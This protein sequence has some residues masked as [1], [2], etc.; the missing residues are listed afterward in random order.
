M[1]SIL[2]RILLLNLIWQLHLFVATAYTPDWDSLDSRPLPSWYDE[3]KLG[4]FMHWGLYAVPSHSEW[5]WWNWI[6]AKNPDVNQFMTDNYKPGFK[7]A[8]FGP[9]F[10]AEFFD[11]DVFAKVV[12]SSG[13]KYFVLTSKHHEGY[14]MYP[15]NFSWNW[16][17]VDV[18]PHRDIVGALQKSMTQAKVR[19][20]LYYSLYE[21]FH[22]LYLEDKGTTFTKK[23]YVKSVMMPQ[24]KEIVS[25]Y[26][27][28]VIWSDGDWEASWQYWNS[29]SFISWLYNESPV[30]KT[31]VVN[32]RWGV[33]TLCQHGDF[34]TCT[35]KYD[36]GRLINRKW[37]RC[38]TLDRYSW[39]FRRTATYQDILTVEEVIA[40]LAK[41]ISCGGNLLLNVGPTHDGR[42]IP[43]FEERLA[44]LGKF[45]SL[46][47]EAIFGT[48]PWI[49]QNDT[50]TPDIWYTSRKRNPTFGSSSPQLYHKQKSIDTIVYAFVLQWPKSGLLELGAPKGTS[51]TA[52]TLLGY[53]GTLNYLVDT[54]T[55]HVVVDFSS[56]FLA[57]MPT[58]LPKTWVLK[59]EYLATDH[60][61]PEILVPQ[62]D[63][64]GREYKRQLKAKSQPNML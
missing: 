38:M 46:N 31:V 10:T 30:S 21:W 37:E 49:Y 35:D 43:I 33:G 34:L 57:D 54:S 15:S 29:T 9:Q 22:P 12:N 42:I 45:T 56:I 64:N 16:N 63:E 62:A 32:D 13:A 25:K 7:Y 27:P 19:F 60:H 23:E 39:G 52:V 11:P 44:Q 4:I 2:N 51:K 17:S 14:T 28:E 1:I 48:K 8:D 55:G 53:N 3:A 24:L 41:T 18:G 59:L 47:Q 58:D 26:K 50:L 5:F 20:G 40:S 61:V 36:P 6:G